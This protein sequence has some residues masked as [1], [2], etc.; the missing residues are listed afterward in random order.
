MEEG[1]E[2]VCDKGSGG[3]AVPWPL[4]A[5]DRAYLSPAGRFKTRNG[6]KI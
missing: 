6:F 5:L 4:G 3:A 2:C 1:G